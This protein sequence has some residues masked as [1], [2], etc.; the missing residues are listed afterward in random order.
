MKPL[1]CV[2]LLSLLMACSSEPTS[3]EAAQQS[4]TA[5]TEADAKGS[6]QAAVAPEMSPQIEVLTKDFWVFEYYVANDPV[7]RETN[8]G[9]W[10]KFAPDGTYESG[11]WSEKTGHGSWRFM[12]DEKFGMLYMDN[13]NDRYDEQWHIQGYDSQYD[14]MTWAGTL[15]AVNQGVIT[16]TINLMTRPT[17]AQFGVE[18]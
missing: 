1:F 13:I 18:E 17:R 11:H 16:K 10:F 14:V 9:R 6:F 2:L 3:Q 15:K 7:A 4:A 5:N 12:P 8:K